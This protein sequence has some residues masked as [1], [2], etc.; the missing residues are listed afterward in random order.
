VQPADCTRLLRALV[1][2]RNVNFSLYL[3]DADTSLERERPLLGKFGCGSRAHV[4]A[5][6]T[7]RWADPRAANAAAEPAAV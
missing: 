5:V 4:L 3:K 6:P 1:R 7:T 2:L